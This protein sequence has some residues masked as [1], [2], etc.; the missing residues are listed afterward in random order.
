MNV[1]E[2]LGAPRIHH[3]WY[4][5]HLFFEKRGLSPDTVSKLESLGQQ[6]KELGGTMGNAMALWRVG[7][8]QLS[9]AADPRGEGAAGA[10]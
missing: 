6:P 9:G 2:A 4:P 5:E 1:S 10:L 3:Q 8:K 7:P